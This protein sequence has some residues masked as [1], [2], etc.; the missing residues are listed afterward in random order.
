LCSIDIFFGE[1]QS[2]HIR[3]RERGFDSGLGL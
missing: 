2:P 1:R 3:Y